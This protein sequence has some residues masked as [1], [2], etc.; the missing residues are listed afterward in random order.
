MLLTCH[1]FKYIGKIN[2]K[3]VELNFDSLRNIRK[4]LREQ[5]CG[6]NILYTSNYIN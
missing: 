5:L 4:S 6:L 1:N 2:G 3:T